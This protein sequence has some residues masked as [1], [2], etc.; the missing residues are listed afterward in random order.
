MYSLRIFKPVNIRLSDSFNE[1]IADKYSKF[2]PAPIQ[3]T[4]YLKKISNLITTYRSLL[5]KRIRCSLLFIVTSSFYYL[6]ILAFFEMPF[7]FSILVY[8]FT[9]LFGTFTFTLPGVPVKALLPSLLL[10]NLVV[11]MVM[12]FNPLHP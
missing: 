3:R 11:L 6:V 7:F 5:N 8:V 10:F 9:L 12:D 4:L 1:L 2:D